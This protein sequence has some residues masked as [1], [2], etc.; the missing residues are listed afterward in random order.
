MGLLFINV[1]N[2]TYSQITLFCSITSQIANFKTNT[3]HSTTF[4]LN[5]N[6]ESRG[7]KHGNC[8]TRDIYHHL[9]ND[10]ANRLNHEA[11]LE[12]HS[13]NKIESESVD[14]FIQFICIWL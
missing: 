5:F 10:L 6:L 7:N 11:N 4:T 13:V 3:T 2:L 14:L 1:L 12:R 9:R 8:G